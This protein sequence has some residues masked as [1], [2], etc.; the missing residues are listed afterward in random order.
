LAEITNDRLSLRALIALPDGS[1]HHRET[2]EGPLTQ[3]AQLGRQAGEALRN[4][5]GVAFFAR[6]QGA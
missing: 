6:L 4:K 3:A 5:A 1:E 2:V